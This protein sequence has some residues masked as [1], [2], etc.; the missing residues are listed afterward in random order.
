MGWHCPICVAQR[1]DQH[2]VES[3]DE[4]KSVRA[5]ENQLCR[6]VLADEEAHAHY[7]Y[8]YNEGALGI[9]AN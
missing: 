1:A 7:T 8:A 3:V 6:A 4:L 9:Q 2:I 5:L